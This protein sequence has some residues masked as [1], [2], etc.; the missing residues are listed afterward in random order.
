MARPSLAAARNRRRPPTDCTGRASS[1]CRP[2]AESKTIELVAEGA[3]KELVWALDEKVLGPSLHNLVGNAVEA[4]AEHGGSK[5]TVRME[6]TPEGHELRLS[7]ADDGP[8]IPA[9]IQRRI[10]DP[11][12][13]TKGS[14]G[15]GL[16][17]ANVK[18]GVEE[19][20][21]RISLISELGKGSQFVLVFP[22]GQSLIEEV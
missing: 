1:R 15:T 20:G 4:I 22:K 17:L 14:K 11:F 12:F 16:G 2:D 3:D 10:F 19:H 5:V 13:S 6:A 7:V 21:G 8:G 18:K 9:D